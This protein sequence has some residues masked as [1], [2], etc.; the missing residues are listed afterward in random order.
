M[1]IFQQILLSLDN[2]L[3]TILEFIGSEVNQVRKDRIYDSR[4][5]E[6]KV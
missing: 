6:L 1:Y 3:V 5:L 4:Q 2:Y